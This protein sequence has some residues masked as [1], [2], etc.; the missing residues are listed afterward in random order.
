MEPGPK[1]TMFAP[2]SKIKMRARVLTMGEVLSC[3]AHMTLPLIVTGV[4]ASLIHRNK[5]MRQLIRNYHIPS[6]AFSDPRVY[7]A[8]DALSVLPL[9]VA[10]HLVYKYGQGF[11][12]QDSAFAL[13]IYGISLTS[14]LTLIPAFRYK[15]IKWIASS[16]SAMALTAFV[17]AYYFF[18]IDKSAGYCMLPYAFWS[19]YYA[20]VSLNICANGVRD[21]SSE[22]SSDGVID[23]GVS[24]E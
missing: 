23:S 17:T 3:G 24:Q 12:H 18:K 14:M 22:K 4:S 6:W 1:R 2:W 8:L 19:S 20:I 13:G 16:A 21:T 7:C 15:S 5:D 11:D 10:S 9:G